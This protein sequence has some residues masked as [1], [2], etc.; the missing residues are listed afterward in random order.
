[1]QKAA[2]ILAS[3]EISIYRLFEIFDILNRAYA[4]ETNATDDITVPNF[5]IVS[6][7]TILLISRLY[8]A[9]I[10]TIASTLSVSQ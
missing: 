5:E 9:T 7:S 8:G 1:M 4:H 2:Y 3:Y 6:I 10:E